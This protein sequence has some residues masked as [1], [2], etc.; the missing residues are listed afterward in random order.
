[1]ELNF[2]MFIVNLL[3]AATIETIILVDV[4]D[5]WTTTV[6]TRPIIKPVKGFLTRSDLK[7]SVTDLPPTSLKDVLIIS[8]EQMK[9]YRAASR[10]KAFNIG[11]V[12]TLIFPIALNSMR[13]RMVYKLILFEI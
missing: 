7:N 13:I 12:I 1:M 8:R 9:K 10:P 2:I 11:I 4:D 6:T 5:D 3:S